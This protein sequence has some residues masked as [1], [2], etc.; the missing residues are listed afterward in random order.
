MLFVRNIFKIIFC[1]TGVNQLIIAVNKLDNVSWSKD[2]FDDIHAKLT[3][4]LVRQAGFKES[5]LTYVPCSGLVGENLSNR[6]TEP[7][8]TAWF[9]GP[10]LLDAI[11]KFILKIKTDFTNL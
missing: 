5:D 9:S 4:F 3:T 10:S 11:S 6:S 2:R 8:L 1:N 7:L